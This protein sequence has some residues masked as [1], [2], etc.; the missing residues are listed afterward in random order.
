MSN[1]EKI[2]ASPEALGKF[3]SSLPIA[4]GPWDE[5]FHRTFCDGCKQ[6]CNH[7]PHEDK[8]NNPAWWL[9]QATEKITDAA[10]CGDTER[11]A[12]GFSGFA[13]VFSAEIAKRL[14]EKLSEERALEP[15]VIAK[16]EN[17]LR[18]NIRAA[19]HGS[20]LGEMLDGENA[21]TRLKTAWQTVE[22]VKKVYPNAEISIEVEV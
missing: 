21:G 8:R 3:L 15:G 7:C 11:Q 9:K 1:F 2:T 10:P 12:V 4:T 20:P 5:S 14:D 19:R 18:V 17:P 13:E 6:T 16:L 22:E